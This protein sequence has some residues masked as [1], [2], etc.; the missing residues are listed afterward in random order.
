MKRILLSITVL[1]FLSSA[2]KVFAAISIS[3]PEGSVR[4]AMP[5]DQVITEDFVEEIKIPSGSRIRCLSG[6]TI[7]RAGEIKINM[8][9][10]SVIQIWVN[11]DESIVHFYVDEETEKNVEVSIGQ[12]L[13]MVPGGNEIR[14]ILDKWERNVEVKVINGILYVGDVIIGAGESNFIKLGLKE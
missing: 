3:N 11:E 5:D 14:T 4:I 9:S 12:D 7:V 2:V 6:S 8:E 10:G 13:F 1:F